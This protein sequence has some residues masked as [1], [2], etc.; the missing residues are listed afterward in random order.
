MKSELLTEKRNP[1]IFFSFEAYYF[2]IL[3]ENIQH[4]QTVND[5]MKY[6]LISHRHIIEKDRF[7]KNIFGYTLERQ[8]SD[9]YIRYTDRVFFLIFS[10]DSDSNVFA[11][12]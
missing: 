5:M 12:I 8:R 3:I 11:E 7:F 10:S 2:A 4:Y 6:Y 1:A 9:L